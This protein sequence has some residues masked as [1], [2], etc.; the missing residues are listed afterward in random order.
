[1]KFAALL[2]LFGVSEASGGRRT[3]ASTYSSWIKSESQAKSML[4]FYKSLGI[5]RVYVDVWH[6]GD[7]LAE[8]STY[9]NLMS[10]SRSDYLGN[11]LSAADQ[12]G[13]IEVVAWFEYGLISCYG[14]CAYGNIARSKG[15]E[16]GSDGGFTWL[17]P[18]NAEFR[19]FFTKM[20]HDVKVNYYN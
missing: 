7:L 13:G 6:N 18:G 20:I 16:L 1:M 2:G 10:S 5:D 17:N 12:V 3:W 4:Q 14:S 15:W 9:S 19:D 8:S 11:V